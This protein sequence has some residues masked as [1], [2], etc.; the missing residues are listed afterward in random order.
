MG[1]FTGHRV[2]DDPEMRFFFNY[3]C[4]RNLLQ[5]HQQIIRT[6]YQQTGR[7][8]LRWK[9]RLWLHMFPEIQTLFSFCVF[10]LELTFSH[11]GCCCPCRSGFFSF[12][13]IESKHELISYE[14]SSS[15][16][17]SCNHNMETVTYHT[18]VT[19]CKFEKKNLCSFFNVK[20][21]SECD[22]LLFLYIKS[23]NFNKYV[24]HHHKLSSTSG[25]VAHSIENN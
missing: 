12:T 9:G 2:H 15:G 16:K 10:F 21:I 17:F 3:H 8:Q 11:G 6:G 23:I 22:M 18:Q 7:M 19:D 13:V 20:T 5:T 4:G 25:L 24:F 1:G 14:I